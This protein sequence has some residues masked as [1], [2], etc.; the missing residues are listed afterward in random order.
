MFIRNLEDNEETQ[1]SVYFKEESKIILDEFKKE[2]DENGISDSLINGSHFKNHKHIDFSYKHYDDIERIYQEKKMNFI[3][4]F[5]DKHIRQKKVV[6]YYFNVLIVGSGNTN[7]SYTLTPHIDASIGRV[8][9]K[10]HILYLSYPNNSIGG[11]LILFSKNDK[12]KVER[13]IKPIP[14]KLVTFQG[15]KYHAISKFN[16]PS[17]EYRISLVWELYY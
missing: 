12:T 8:A 10:V 17:K 11:D 5:F 2:Y 6:E 15:N 16:C 9:S 3:Y 4:D 14:G 13:V 7:N 1:E